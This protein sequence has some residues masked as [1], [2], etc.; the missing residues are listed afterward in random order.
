MTFYVRPQFLLAGLTL[1]SSLVM[2]DPTTESRAAARSSSGSGSAVSASVQHSL[3]TSG[4][5]VSGVVAVPL[6]GSIFGS[7]AVAAQLEGS[8]AT[9]PQ[10][11]KAG[12]PLPVT[13]ENISVLPPNKVLQ[14]P[15]NPPKNP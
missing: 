11:V 10:P 4:Q 12:Q 13:E 8:T 1:L 15:A 2:A 9:A 3:A 7:V 5:V 14:K 6:V